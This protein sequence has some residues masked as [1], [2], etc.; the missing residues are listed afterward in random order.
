MQLILLDG[1][2]YK[3]LLAEN[4]MYHNHFGLAAKDF[5]KQKHPDQLFPLTHTPLGPQLSEPHRRAHE[6][7]YEITVGAKIPRFAGHTYGEFILASAR[8]H[9][10]EAWRKDWDMMLPAKYT[11]PGFI[12][13]NESTGSNL[14]YYVTTHGLVAQAILE[15]TVSTW[16]DQLDLGSC[17]PWKDTV[18]FGNIRTLLS[19][20]VSGEIKD[21]SGQATLHAWKDTNFKY[22]GQAITLK[23]GQKMTVKIE[24]SDKKL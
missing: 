14:A 23:K 19:V 20:T 22:Q 12:Q 11:D 7:R 16:W 4:G 18:R 8:M 1:L 2:A 21:G 17:I 5:G 6:L 13:F 24:Q 15:T 9:D 10:A 3:P